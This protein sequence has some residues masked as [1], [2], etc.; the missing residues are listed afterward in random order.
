VRRGGFAPG[1]ETGVSVVSDTGPLNYLILTESIHVLPVIFGG[2]IRTT[3]GLGGVEEIEAIG[4]RA[5]PPLGKFSTAMA[6]DQ[7]TCRD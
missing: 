7:G 4:A 5:C 6:H 3:S 2:G 1:S